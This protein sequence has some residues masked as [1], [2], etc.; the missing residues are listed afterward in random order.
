MMNMMA[1][2]IKPASASI[3]SSSKR[4]MTVDAETRATQVG[5]RSLI[6]DDVY[7]LGGE[8]VGKVE[9]MILD[10]HTG[11]VRYVVVS[12]G[13]FLGFGR[14]HVAVP[15]SALTPDLDYQRCVVNVMAMQLMAVPV[16]DEDPWLQ[17]YDPSRTIDY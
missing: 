7:D 13:G 17:R 2:L 10:I 11:C 6:K 16:F 1:S 12:F 3:Q 14:K 9:E 15:W 5:A 4:P 8:R